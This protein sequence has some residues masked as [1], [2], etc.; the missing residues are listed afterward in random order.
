MS[1]KVMENDPDY[2]LMPAKAGGHY[3]G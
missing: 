3:A 2:T 1:E